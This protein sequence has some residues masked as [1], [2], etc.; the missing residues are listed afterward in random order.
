MRHFTAVTGVV[1]TAPNWAEQLTGIGSVLAGLGF[2]AAAVALW[3]AYN[4][5]KE[6]RRDR[7]IQVISE[8]GRRWDSRRVQSA[9]RIQRVY[10]GED[11]QRE[12]AAWINDPATK[13]DVD[14]LLRLP[15]FFEDLAIIS[16]CGKLDIE[17]ITMA[18][19]SIIIHQWE[20]WNPSIQTMR[21]TAPHD[22]EQ[23][24]G[25]VKDVRTHQACQERQRRRGAEWKRR[26][27]VA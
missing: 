13:P 8:F 2:I 14:V 21:Q 6:T 10:P 1:A 3:F 15:N 7:H 9:R 23:F 25:L 12:V 24:E 4:Q 20:Y 18:M 11:L 16:R 27:S 22:Y 5:L 26:R 19:G 17:L